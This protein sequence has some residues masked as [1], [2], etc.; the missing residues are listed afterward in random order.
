MKRTVSAR[1]RFHINNGIAMRNEY[2][3]F[4][5]VDLSGLDY[6]DLASDA[7][8]WILRSAQGDTKAHALL[9]RE[10]VDGELPRSTLAACERLAPESW[11]MNC[12]PLLEFFN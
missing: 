2:Y 8:G 11:P 3:R 5:N 9:L 7:A 10:G 1:A 12:A 4:A 6:K